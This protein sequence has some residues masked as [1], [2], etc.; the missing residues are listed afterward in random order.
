MHTQPWLSVLIPAFNT[1]DYLSECVNSILSQ[2]NTGV[3][4]ILYND[5]STDGTHDICLRFEQD[6]PA[7]LASI[8][9]LLTQMTL[10][11][12]IALSSSKR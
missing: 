7:H 10:L 11:Y 5:G 2:Q 6:N 4:V 12:P 3:E 1:E 9:G 8:F